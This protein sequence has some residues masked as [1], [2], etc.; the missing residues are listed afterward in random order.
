[1][2]KTIE[3]IGSAAFMACGNLKYIKIKSTAPPQIQSDTFDDYSGV[4]YVPIE[5]YVSYLEDSEW[6]K[7]GMKRRIL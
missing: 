3:K 6:G 4:F 7:D 1:M 5:N 2:P